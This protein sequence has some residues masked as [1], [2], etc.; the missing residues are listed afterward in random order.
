MI[1]LNRSPRPRVSR[2][3]SAQQG[4]RGDSDWQCAYTDS[5][6][7]SAMRVCHPGPVAFQR[8]MVSGCN[9]RLIATFECA[10]LGRPRGLSMAAAVRAPK[11]F[12]KTSLAGRAFAIMAVV[13]SGF[14]R[15]GFLGLA[16]FFMASHLTFISFAQTDDPRLAVAWGKNHAMQPIL[17]EARHAVTVFSV[18]F[19]LVFPD[20]SRRPVALLGKFQ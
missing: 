4:R 5:R 10:D 2:R 14:S 3:S 15:A 11:I 7:T 17:D 20:Q 18:V 9:L 1:R 13:H 12:G 19:T 8:A 16:C 6:S